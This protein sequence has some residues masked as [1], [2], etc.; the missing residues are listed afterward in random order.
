MSRFYRALL[1]GFF[2]AIIGLI[3][4]FSPFGLKLEENTGL[5]LLFKLRGIR[6]TP[7]DVIVV[8]IDRL[9]A[10]KLNLP[11]DPG[12]WPRSFHANLI[13]NLSYEGASVIA[14]D[15]I[16]NE[17]RSF[18]DDNLFANTMSREGNVV[19]SEYIMQKTPFDDIGNAIEELHIEKLI[20]PIP[21][22]AQSAFAVACFPLPKVPFK[23][24]Q[25]WTFKKTAG[26]VPTLPIVV[27]Q[28]F[29]LGVYDE[30]IRLLE[31]HS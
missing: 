17:A 6:Q 14:F 2:I 16:F 26:D 29:T 9:S 20:P 12:K 10:E 24:S 13:E 18:K 5:S 25:Y 22:L 30:F 7:A 19:L 15:L 8:S 3:I 27:F 4:A 1:L 28:S 23:V 31:K 11:D 21:L